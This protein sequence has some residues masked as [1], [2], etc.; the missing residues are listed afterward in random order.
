[1]IDCA[2]ELRLQ[3]Q[4]AHR[5]HIQPRSRRE[6]SRPDSLRGQSRVDIAVKVDGSRRGQYT[7]PLM[8]LEAPER[9]HA[10]VES[11]VEMAVQVAGKLK[12]T[13]VVPMDS[14]QDTVMAEAVKLEK[15]QRAMEGMDVVKVI[16]KTNKILNLILKPK[17]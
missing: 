10:T 11:S 1:M 7:G 16:F 14:D 15:V 4:C 8:P 17:A 13:V 2:A 12:G 5:I 3:I 9:H 6:H